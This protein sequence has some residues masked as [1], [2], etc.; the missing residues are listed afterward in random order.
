M[1]AFRPVHKAVQTK[2]DKLKPS[3]QNRYILE[4]IEDHARLTLVAAGADSP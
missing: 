2:Y 4:F 1:R 3:D